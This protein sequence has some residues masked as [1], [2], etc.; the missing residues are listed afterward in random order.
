MIVIQF[1]PSRL[2]KMKKL[3]FLFLIYVSR[4]QGGTYIQTT[5]I[6]Q[7]TIQTTRR[8]FI[9]TKKIVGVFLIAHMRHKKY[10]DCVWSI[11]VM[12]V[13]VFLIGG[14]SFS[15]QLFQPVPLSPSPPQNP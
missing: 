10:S 5:A 7:K 14:E 12:A 9:D 2:K 6:T 4:D 1:E 8:G 13:Y 3:L 15:H 11:S